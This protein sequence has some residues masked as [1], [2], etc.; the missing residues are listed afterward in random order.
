MRNLLPLK[1]TTG[2]EPFEYYVFT[3]FNHNDNLAELIINGTNR[4]DVVLEVTDVHADIS[5]L[6]AEVEMGNFSDPALKVAR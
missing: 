4:Y 6:I 3:E 1:K 5:A 2:A